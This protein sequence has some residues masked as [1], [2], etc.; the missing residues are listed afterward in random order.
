M[1]AEAAAAQRGRGLPSELDNLSQS[2]ICAT[3]AVVCLGLN[4]KL[5][6]YETKQHLQCSDCIPVRNFKTLTAARCQLG[7]FC[8][9]HT[10]IS[11]HVQRLGH[12]PELLPSLAL[13]PGP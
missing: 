5:I 7:F 9:E 11:R 8:M 13:L 2:L 10:V 3:L 4:E 6:L 12:E 1:Y